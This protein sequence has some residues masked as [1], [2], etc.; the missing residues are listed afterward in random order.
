MR[1]ER[2]CD[3]N[4]HH[5]E[6]AF[7]LYESA[8]PTEERRDIAEQERAIGNS[9]YHFDLITDEDNLLGIM[10]YWE[11]DDFVF[12]EHFTT[13]PEVRN[14][15]IGAGALGILKS[16]GKP[17]LLEIEPPKD[18]MTERRY[19]FYKRNGFLMNPYY[20]I[21]AK[22]HVGDADLELKILSYPQILTEEQYRGFYEY[23][24]RE[25][26]IKPSIANDIIIRGLKENDDYLQ[27]A[28]LIYLTDPYIYP[29]WFRDIDEG[30]RVIA[31]MIRLPTLYRQEN[32][33]VAV[34][35]DGF[36]A[37]ATVS[38]ECPF[39]EDEADIRRAFVMADVEIDEERTH[40][41]YL[42]YYNKMGDAEDGHYIANVATDPDYRGRGIA[43]AML[44]II[45]ADKPLST[46]ECVVKNAG[47]LRLYQRLGFKIDFEYPGVFDVPCYRMSRKVVK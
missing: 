19:S 7:A 27:V 17:V 43:A 24:T 41:I 29:Y 18:E 4:R 36:I 37:G 22:Y 33:T 28:K 8:F 11:T 32:I 31:E 34:T 40:R 20:H 13:L 16:K 23:M 38:A 15:G 14:R 30:K 42:D 6:R 12:L 46:L 2:L 10:L 3:S 5:F 1:L 39:N 44:S 35:P 9:N 21:Q 47:S 45:T 25:I 26:G